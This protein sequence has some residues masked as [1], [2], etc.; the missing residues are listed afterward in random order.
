MMMTKRLIST[1]YMLT[2]A[3]ALSWAQPNNT[4]SYYA[5]ANGKK[6]S[7]LKT[8]MCGIINGKYKGTQFK[9]IAYGSGTLNGVWGAFA[10]TDVLDDGK[11]IRDRYS[12]ITHYTV[13]DDQGSSS[14][15]E[16][17]GGYNRE[18]S[19]PK[20]WFGGSTNIG[21]GTD[22]H[23]I[24]PTDVMVNS[25]RGNL[26]YGENNGESWKSSGG[27]SKVGACTYDGFS[28]DCFEPA[29]EWKGD[30]ARAY[31]YM[32]T[33]YESDQPSWS[34]EMLSKNTYPSFKEWALN[35]L[36]KWARQDPVSDIEIARNEAVCAIQHNRNPF[37][38]YPGLEEYIWGTM[39]NVE[40]DYTN[41]Q[42]TYVAPPTFSPAGGTYTTT[43]N[44]TLSCAT[45]GASIYYTTDGTTPS[46]SSTPYESAITI[47][48]TTT[49]KVIAI[50]EGVSSEVVEATFT[51][52]PETPIP[53]NDTL[54]WESFSGYT[55]AD[56]SQEI[57][58][59]NGKLDYDKWTTFTKVYFGQNGCGKLGSSSAK[60]SMEATGI[61]LS[62]NGV[63]TFK[64]KRYGS[65]TGK[66]NVTITGAMATGDKQVTPPDNW[67][68]YT[69]NLTNANGS[70]SLKFETTKRAYIDDI[71][72]VSANIPG[73]VNND[74]SINV[75]DVT[76]LVNIILGKD[77]TAPY[78]YNHVSAD[79]NNDKK[80]D[81]TDVTELVNMV[82]AGG[83]SN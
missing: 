22:L 19:F 64:V 75:T 46:A 50:K 63:L 58:P 10:T 66:L 6:G 12:N 68:E 29:N 44:V 31:F 67:T 65:D 77:N 48:T 41:G 8:A 42:V 3:V 16:G 81:I 57:N 73:D 60:G 20:S 30:F 17:T 34:S 11:T 37:I 39:T 55:G 45:N 61:Q 71:K 43:Q 35:L 33:C 59:S 13:G 49:L 14:A 74:G 70:V 18:H 9:Q 56:G 28:N 1:V 24:Y 40:F 38:D 2:M 25:H 62:G 78:I 83:N 80:V 36:L 26:P 15:T 69:I 4:G 54:V 21:P 51:I 7:E 32:V 72:L 23:H 82:L 27:Y 52:Q 5:A 53:S 47:S 76:A 79:V